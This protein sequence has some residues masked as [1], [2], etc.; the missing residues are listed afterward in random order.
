MKHVPRRGCGRGDAQ[1]VCQVISEVGKVNDQGSFEGVVSDRSCGCKH[2]HEDGRPGYQVA[3]A[4][5]E[6]SV[7]SGDKG[8]VSIVEPEFQV[9][10]EIIA[11]QQGRGQ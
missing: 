8:D 2:V 9:A 3:M 1:S 6:A 7:L 5:A 10:S 4:D 11:P